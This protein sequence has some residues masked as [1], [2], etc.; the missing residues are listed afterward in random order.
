MKK[1]HL[2]DLMSITTDV[3]FHSP[4]RELPIHGVRAVCNFMLGGNFSTFELPSAADH[5]APELVKQHPFLGEIDVTGVNESN[6]SEFQ[7]EMVAKY[8][9]YF[10][11]KALGE[12][13]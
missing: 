11:V 8:G 12:M 5:C 2:A 1:F 9:D 13:G 10:E 4:D 3:I 7:V 6:F